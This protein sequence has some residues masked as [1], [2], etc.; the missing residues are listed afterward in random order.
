MF[1]MSG[2]FRGNP[3]AGADLDRSLDVLP[4]RL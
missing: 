2:I 1:E 3:G 4:T